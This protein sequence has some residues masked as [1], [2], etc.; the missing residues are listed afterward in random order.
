MWIHY[1][2]AFGELL[3]LQLILQDLLLGYFMNFLV[4]CQCIACL[5]RNG[6]QAVDKTE[7]L[8]LESNIDL[9]MNLGNPF[10]LKLCLLYIQNFEYVK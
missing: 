8:G 10:F 3:L 6:S 9:Y 7:Q 4:W 1:P 2:E 5:T